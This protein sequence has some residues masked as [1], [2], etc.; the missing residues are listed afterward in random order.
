MTTPKSVI[1]R[2]P[3][4]Q[5]FQ[6]YLVSETSVGNISRQEV[7]S[8][9]PPL[10]MD[11]HPGMTVLDMCAAPGSKAAQI[12][13]MI[14]GGEEACIQKFQR[15]RAKNGG[16]EMRPGPEEVEGEEMDMDYDDDG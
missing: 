7:V 6:K 13:E 10:L 2:F 16:R 14:H 5:A 3:P 9:I 8:M 11:I 12:L 1:R 15:Q 4:F